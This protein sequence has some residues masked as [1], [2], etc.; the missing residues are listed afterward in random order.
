[1]GIEVYFN[2]SSIERG[3]EMGTDIGTILAE[4]GARY[5]DFAEQAKIAQRLKTV[6]RSAERD[7]AELVSMQ[8]YQREAIEMICHKLA[9][10]VNGDP[11][12]ADSWTDIAGYAKLVADQLQ[13]VDEDQVEA[14]AR[15]YRTVM[16]QEDAFR[17]TKPIQRF[18]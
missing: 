2:V 15:E 12:Y 17:N 7:V 1:M 8:D 14:S 5:G 16:E 4:R 3:I 18:D 11:Y 10:I 13:R 6:L 9:R